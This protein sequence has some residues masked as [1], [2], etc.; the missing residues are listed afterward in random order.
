MCADKRRYFILV[1]ISI[2]LLCISAGSFATS[3]TGEASDTRTTQAIACCRAYLMKNYP[4]VSFD[5]DAQQ[6]TNNT[7]GITIDKWLIVF[8]AEQLEAPSW[9]WFIYMNPPGSIISSGDS[10]NSNAPLSVLDYNIALLKWESTRGLFNFWTVEDKALFNEQI[11]IPMKRD[12]HNILPNEDDVPVAEAIQIARNSLTDRFSLT[13]S[14]LDVLWQGVFFSESG[15]RKHWIVNY[16]TLDL[17]YDYLLRNTY[18]VVID[19][20]TGAVIDLISY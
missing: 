17:T 8:R 13:G 1:V 12:S 16:W 10:G 20:D 14:E 6:F 9:F 4:N 5:A 11:G 15:G 18:A 19:A 7:N 2:L 3:T